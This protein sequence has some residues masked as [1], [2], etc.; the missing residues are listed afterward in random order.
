MN[1]RRPVLLNSWEAA[2]FDIDEDKL[3]DIA[4]SAKDAGAELFVMDDGWF[5]RRDDDTT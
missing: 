3:V 5:G 4:R 2:Y 1:R